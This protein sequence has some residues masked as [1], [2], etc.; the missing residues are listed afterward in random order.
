MKPTNPTIDAQNLKRPKDE[1]AQKTEEPTFEAWTE[2][3]TELLREY[4]DLCDGL[5]RAGDGG[6]DGERR[7]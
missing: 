4:H 1:A 3:W 6:K 2:F 5:L 7:G